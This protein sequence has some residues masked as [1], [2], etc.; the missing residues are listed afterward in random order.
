MGQFIGKICSV[1]PMTSCARV[2]KRKHDDKIINSKN[3]RNRCVTSRMRGKKNL[4]FE[5]FSFSH[6]F[7]KEKFTFYAHF[8]EFN[9]KIIT[10]KCILLIGIRG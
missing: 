6:F 8:Y 5:E 3:T 7:S 4:S 1:N 2:V 10:F 9:Y